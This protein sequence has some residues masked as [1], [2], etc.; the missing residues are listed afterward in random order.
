MF[1]PHEHHIVVR[2]AVQKEVQNM[3]AGENECYKEVKQGEVK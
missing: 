1:Q 3:I 2:K